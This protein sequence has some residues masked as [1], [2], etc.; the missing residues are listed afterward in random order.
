ME[1][2]GNKVSTIFVEAGKNSDHN[3]FFFEKN[4]KNEKCLELP[5][6]ARKLIRK[7][8][9][10]FFTPPPGIFFWK[11]N[12]KCLEFPD[13]ARKLVRKIFWK[14]YPPPD[15]FFFEKNEKCLELPDLARKLIR[16][17]AW[18]FYPPPPDFLGLFKAT[19]QTREPK[20][21]RSRRWGAERRVSRAQTRERGPPSAWAEIITSFASISLTEA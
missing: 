2:A 8:F 6:L 13:L 1:M 20:N 3:Y 16:T 11:K 12:E 18:K 21:F 10:N 14:L 19:L 7:I 5:D 4:E 9:W 15:F 17:F